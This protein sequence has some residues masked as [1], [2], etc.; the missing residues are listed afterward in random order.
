MTLVPGVEPALLIQ[1]QHQR[2]GL[3][4]AGKQGVAAHADLPLTDADL[5]PGQGP[6]HYPGTGRLAGADLAGHL[7]EAIA[8]LGGEPQGLELVD[9]GLRDG[10]T[11]EQQLAQAG[12]SGVEA[13]RQQAPE[14]GRHQ[15]E[16]GDGLVLEPLLEGLGAIVQHQAGPRQ[17]DPEQD[18]VAA[19]V[20][21]RQGEQPA[22]VAIE[23]DQAGRAPGRGE[24]VGE[25]VH[26]RFGCAAG[27]RGEDHVV[28]LG[29]FK[30]PG[31]LAC[32]QF[33]RE[34]EPQWQPA[35]HRNLPR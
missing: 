3:E 34:V 15:R 13:L 8:R 20:K 2:S 4:I 26:H 11:A 16:V 30:R 25:A 21:Q 1:R 32:R 19:H 24:V 12:A 22:A 6:A 14:L 27:S 31:F 7:G 9:Q 35:P 18:G 23:R 10:G 28:E 5:P 33:T 29:R 17:E